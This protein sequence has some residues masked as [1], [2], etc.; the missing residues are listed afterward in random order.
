VFL[1]SGL[2]SPLPIAL[3][4]FARVRRFLMCRAP[5]AG[6]DF[7]THRNLENFVNMRGFAAAAAGFLLAAASGSAFAAGDYG[8]G[9]P[10]SASVSPLTFKG[11]VLVNAGGMTVYTFDKD[12]EAGGKPACNGGC[13]AKWPPAMAASSDKPQGQFTIVVRDDGGRQWAYKGMPVYTW[14]GDKQPG[15]KT[16]DNFGKLWHVVPQ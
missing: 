15:D 13:S 10:A 6:R 14:S 4:C 12:M 11:G 16:G 7:A 9:I 5:K 1:C 2:T 8:D 3:S